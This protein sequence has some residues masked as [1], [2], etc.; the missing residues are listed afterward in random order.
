VVKGSKK[1]ARKPDPLLADAQAASAEGRHDEAE[2]LFREAAARKPPS[3]EAL[4]FLGHF[5][6][7]TGRP[8]DAIPF[9]KRARRLQPEVGE[10]DL[11]LGFAYQDAGDAGQAE[12]LGSPW[13]ICKHCRT[14][15]RTPPSPFATPSK[16][17]R[18][19]PP[20]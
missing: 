4:F 18:T 15:T 3:A 19:I 5:L 6:Q 13:A 17:G 10:I 11:Q 7:E 9:L 20:P 2:R 16:S 8:R 12:K 14:V 1:S